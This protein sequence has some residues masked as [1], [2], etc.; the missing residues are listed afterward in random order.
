MKK[1]FPS[2]RHPSLAVQ[3]SNHPKPTPR[4]D[5]SPA[6]PPDASGSR[7]GTPAC[8]D[9]LPPSPNLK[10]QAVVLRQLI[11]VAQIRP[12]PPLQADLSGISRTGL[13]VMQPL[14]APVFEP[15]TLARCSSR[16]ATLWRLKRRQGPESGASVPSANGRLKEAVTIGSHGSFEPTGAGN[17]PPSEGLKQHEQPAQRQSQ[18]A[19]GMFPE[20]PSGRHGCQT[21]NSTGNAPLDTDVWSKEFHSLEQGFTDL[22]V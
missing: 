2:E 19:G 4:S 18:A 8:G 22:A 7:D 1:K 14:F 6:V 10:P 16:F 21:A 11:S 13:F 15:V 9:S 12:K 20:K 17:A 5:E 3:F